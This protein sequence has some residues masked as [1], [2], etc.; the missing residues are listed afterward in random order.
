MGGTLREISRAML[1]GTAL[2]NASALADNIL[3]LV[4]TNAATRQVMG[5]DAYRSETQETVRPHDYDDEQYPDYARYTRGE[6]Q[7]QQSLH[8]LQDRERTSDPNQ[9]PAVSEVS[10]NLINR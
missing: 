8:D 5:K 7:D 1:R 10:G 9:D 2:G 6:Y 3:E 4:D